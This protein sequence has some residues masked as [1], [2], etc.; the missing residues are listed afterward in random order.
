MAGP[1]DHLLAD[2]RGRGFTGHVGLRVTALDGTEL[3]AVNADRVFPA[4][5]TIKVPLLVMALEWAQRG[6]LDLDA[7]VVMQDADR[8]PGA[9]VLHDLCGGLAL[10]WRDVLTLMIVVSDNTAT[11]L[12]IGH[13]GVGAVNAWLDHHG[14]AHTRLIGKLQLPPEQRNAAQRRGERNRTTAF[15]QTAL[16][17]ALARGD[18]LDAAHTALALDIL[19]RQ[20]HRDVIG[21]RLPRNADGTP[22][23]RL[24]S[25]SGELEGVH[26]DVGVLYTPRPLVVALLSEG[27]TDR[28]EHPENRDVALL[29]DALWPLLAALGE[30]DAGGPSGDI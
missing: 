25:K 17:G 30:G 21:R 19:A 1:A 23:Y 12:V 24:C 13:V 22:R 26:H 28:R 5:S 2:L 7:R 27:G 15:E 8:V 3:A 14:H 9:G 10:T 16:L 29:A 6:D 20:Q 18:V 4:A 11:N